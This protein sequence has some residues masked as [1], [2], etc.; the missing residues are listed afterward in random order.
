MRESSARL[1]MPSWCSRPREKLLREGC[2]K[3]E[4]GGKGNCRAVGVTY[5]ITCVTCEAAGK[6]AKY[7]GQSARSGFSRGR[8][9]RD[10]MRRRADDS[11]IHAHALECHGGEMPEVRM[12][13]TGTYEGDPTLRQVS[14]AV[15]I[16]ALPAKVLLNQKTEW[17]INALPH[18]N[19]SDSP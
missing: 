8:E 16:R 18:L 11:R 4:S 15:Q 17:N 12:D 1:L 3:C 6:A 2:L 10:G 9:H 7:V 14:E 5:V 13:I 19:L